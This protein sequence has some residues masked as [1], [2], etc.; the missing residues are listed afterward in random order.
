MAELPA[1]TAAEA[2]RS[3][4]WQIVFGQYLGVGAL[5]IISLAVAWGTIFLPRRISPEGDGYTLRFLPQ[6]NG[7][8]F[9]LLPQ[10]GGAGLERIK[11]AL[12]RAIF[13]S[14]AVSASSCDGSYRAGNHIGSACPASE[15][16]LEARFPDV[17]MTVLAVAVQ[18]GINIVENGA[19][20]RIQVPSESCGVIGEPST[21][22][23]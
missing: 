14:A 7:E 12:R 1:G 20:V 4:K 3:R 23:A 10:S 16:H 9:A 5:V 17:G 19:R 11:P 6:H 8:A 22:H 18:V 21:F 13:T 2:V 15:I